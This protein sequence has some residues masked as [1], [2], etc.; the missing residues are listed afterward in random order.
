MPVQQRK[1]HRSRTV[2]DAWG[3][4]VSSTRAR[5]HSVPFPFPPPPLA[6]VLFPTPPCTCREHGTERR[7]LPGLVWFGLRPCGRGRLCPPA[8]CCCAADAAAP[9]HRQ[10]AATES[11][12]ACPCWSGASATATA[13]ASAQDCRKCRPQ[14]FRTAA[15]TWPSQPSSHPGR[16]QRGRPADRDRCSPTGGA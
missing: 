16:L 9:V 8:L 14:A 1:C 13:S 12:P 10:A 15:P 6:L 11:A 7:R 3:V 4:C 5:L 2:C